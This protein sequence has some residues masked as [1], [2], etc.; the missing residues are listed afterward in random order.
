MKSRSTCVA[1][2]RHPAVRAGTAL[3]LVL[4]GFVSQAS[5]LPKGALFVKKDAVVCAR[6]QDIVK[7]RKA[8]NT[9][10]HF[11]QIR[12]LVAGGRCQIYGRR[13]KIVGFRPSSP[14]NRLA[15]VQI[16][17]EDSP[18]VARWILQMDLREK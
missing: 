4:P 15:A 16:R 3:I 6:K 9:L 10:R 13:E 18:D 8:L 7:V 11:G 2:R 12:A 5:M 1:M 17:T 14:A